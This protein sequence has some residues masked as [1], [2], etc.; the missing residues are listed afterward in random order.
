MEEMV[1]ENMEEGY[2]FKEKINLKI[3]LT[4]KRFVICW[5]FI[6]KSYS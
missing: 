5:K 1:K 6:W 2:V 4:L 3:L